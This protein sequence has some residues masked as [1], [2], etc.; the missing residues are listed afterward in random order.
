MAA[1]RDWL[2]ATLDNLARGESRLSPLIYDGHPAGN[3]DGERYWQARAT[4]LDG[5]TRRHCAAGHGRD[6]PDRQDRAEPPRARQAALPGR[7]RQVLVDEANAASQTHRK[8]L[9]ELLAF[10]KV[11]AWELDVATGYMACTDQ[12]KA[13]MGLCSRTTPSTRRASSKN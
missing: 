5:A 2:L 8:R 1:R 13:N 11:G 4:R 3:G 12:C 7:L 10:A 9:E 6:R